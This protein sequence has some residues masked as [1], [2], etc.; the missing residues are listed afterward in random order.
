VRWLL[1]YLRCRSIPVAVAAV[2]GSTAVLW[3]LTQLVDSPAT[4]AK[5][6]L[7]A[8]IAAAVAIA[9][10]LAGAD[11]DLDRTAAIAWPPRRAAHVLAATAAGVGIL[12]ATALTGDPL[13][14][15]GPFVRNVIGLA[16]LIAL[17]A[18][19]FGASRAWLLPATWILLLLQYTPPFGTPPD[20]P[21]YKVMLTW[22]MQPAETPSATIAAVILASPAHWRMRSSAPGGWF[23]MV[24]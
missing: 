3:W 8:A 17:G 9:P 21:T 12:G 22:L 5:L 15:A 18:A 23:R 24:T 16:G 10:G 13:T 4:R 14:Q 20:Q 2:L 6:A 1:L 11:G 19:T 7:M